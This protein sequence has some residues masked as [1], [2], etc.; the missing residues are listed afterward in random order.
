MVRD[1]VP[2]KMIA[3]RTDLTLNVKALDKHAKL[4]TKSH[5]GDL[6]YDLYALEDT[7]L[8]PGKVTKVRTGIAMGFPEGHG[9]LIRDRSSVATK[10]EVFVVGGVIDQGY[11][12]EVLVAMYNPGRT[13]LDYT[14]VS[15]DHG[16]L[17]SREY[18]TVVDHVFVRPA[19]PC[20]FKA[21]DKIAQIIL[22]PV[23]TF[24][25]KEVE[26]LG[27]TDRGSN[28]FGSTGTR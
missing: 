28:G 23:I 24:P 25:V 14:Y 6:G 1:S 27:H 18:T 4:P 26:E 9:G 20:T 15:I 21:G 12:G 19:G 22:I 3:V 11:T 7:V 5:T 13:D 16:G 17:F 8:E 2:H 10:Q